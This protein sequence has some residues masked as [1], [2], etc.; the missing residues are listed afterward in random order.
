MD[1]QTVFFLLVLGYAVGLTAAIAILGGRQ[2]RPQTVVIHDSRDYNGTSG[3]GAYFFTTVVV[4]MLLIL[5]SRF[6]G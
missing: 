3:C 5:I 1:A 4:L 6:A 2:S